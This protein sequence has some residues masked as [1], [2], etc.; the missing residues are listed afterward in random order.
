MSRALIEVHNGGKI[1]K[2]LRG[3]T[4]D[5]VHD[6]SMDV[7]EG[8]FVSIVGPSGCGK[9]TLLRMIGGLILPTSGSIVVNGKELEGPVPDVGFVFQNPTLFPWQTVLGNVL[10]PIR[11]KRLDRSKFTDKAQDMIRLVGLEGF[12][13]KYPW[14]LSGGMQQRVSIARALMND[15]KI[16]LMD[17]PFGAL[18]ALTRE[19]MRVELIRIWEKLRITAVFVTHDVPEAVLLSERVIAMSRRPGKII[20]TFKIDL[21]HPRDLTIMGDANFS[22]YT[23]EIRRSLGLIT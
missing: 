13:D 4:V 12:H 3:G 11:V 8:E 20:K 6:V 2:S 7:T 15:P 19:E 16:L 9:T 21:P 1:F 23:K 14:E 22:N 10:L 17:E 18:D 5:A